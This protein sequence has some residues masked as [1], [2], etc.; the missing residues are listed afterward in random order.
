MPFVGKGAATGG[1]SDI[2]RGRACLLAAQNSAAARR[3]AER[4][5]DQR[6]VIRGG[7]RLVGDAFRSLQLGKHQ[8]A[9]ADAQFGGDRHD[10]ALGVGISRSHHLRGL[11]DG[12]EAGPSR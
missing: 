1:G 6:L 9:F 8:R 3:G 5:V 11:E 7:N 4:S 10:L 2:G 12:D